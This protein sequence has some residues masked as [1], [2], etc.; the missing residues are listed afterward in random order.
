MAYKCIRTRFDFKGSVSI[1]V[2]S[3]VKSKRAARAYAK[4]LQAE[5]DAKLGFIYKY[6]VQKE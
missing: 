5:E 1:T 4:T 2:F 3:G 6:E